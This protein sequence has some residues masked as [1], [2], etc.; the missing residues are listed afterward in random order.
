MRFL[1]ILSILIL[2]GSSFGQK[3]HISGQVQDTLNSRGVE[4]AVVMAVRVKDSVLINFVR[5]DWKGEFKLDLPRD[6]FQVFIT[7]PN[8][9]QRE[10]F[11]FGNASTKDLDFGRI[12]L[13]PKGEELKELVVFSNNQP[14][15]FKGDTLV[16]VADSFKTAANANVEDLFKKLPGFEVDNSGKI[17]VH[18]KEVNKVYVDG[19]EFFGTDPTVATK[20]LPASAIE[21]VE[22]YE[23][24]VEGDNTEETEKV[25]NLKLKE[26]AKQGYF[27][28]INGAS[29]FNNYYEGEFL[30][31]KFN[32]S[33]KISVFGLFT[34]TPRSEFNMRDRFQYG[35][36]EE[37]GLRDEDWNY[38]YEPQIGNLGEGVPQKAKTGFYY[39]DKIGKKVEIGT[40]FT[41]D[42]QQVLSRKESFTQYNLSDTTYFNSKLDSTLQMQEAYAL[43]FKLEWKID[44][45]TKLDI[46]PRVKQIQNQTFEYSVTDF[47]SEDNVNTR[48]TEIDYSENMIFQEGSLLVDLEKNFEK[49]NRKLEATY[50]IKHQSNS[51]KDYLSNKDRDMVELVDYSNLDQTKNGKSVF[52]QHFANLQFTEPI[53]KKVMLEVSYAYQVASGYNKKYTFDNDGTDYNLLNTTYTSDFDNT[54]SNQKIGGKVIFG[55]KIHQIIAG[56]YYNITDINSTDVFTDSSLHKNLGNILPYFKYRIKFSQSKQLTFKYISNVQNPSISQLQPI[57]NNRNINNIKLGNINLISEVSNQA[58]VNYFTYKATSGSHRYVGMNYTWYKN[59]LSNGLYYDNQGRVINQTINVSGGEMLT[60]YFGGQF[61]FLKQLL[62]FSPNINYIRNVNISEINF[63]ESTNENNSIYTNLVAQ[64]IT[65]SVEIFAGTEIGYNY[66]KTALSDTW[67]KYSTQTY[68]AGFEWK[69]RG[70]IEIGSEVRYIV[71]TQRANGYDLTYLLWDAS[72][73]K[74]FLPKENLIISFEAND[75]LNQN[76]SNTRSIYNNTIVDTKTNIIGRYLLLRAVYKFN[77]LKGQKNDDDLL[78]D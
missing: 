67:Q 39:T 22:V 35:L 51:S 58:S 46:V 40:N 8:F 55:H 59:P 12:I 26:D 34:N 31:N 62:K 6:T 43:N 1:I 7:H 30:V 57:P 68:K 16:M 42:N 75:I 47:Y 70:K 78:K 41:Y 19:D 63:V 28:K 53:S 13:P 60:G 37:Y 9:E 17:V 72:I 33:Q 71:N 18:G 32:G 54:T 10:F 50:Q 11:I 24:K 2:T 49:K 5:T 74:M 4:Y 3:I 73:S 77:V 56:A 14:I 66:A 52:L 61:P 48:S 64:M 20:N 25:I 29:D 76:I 27:G 23:Q 69:L 44:S 65:D 15:Y 38:V 45:L 36:T 21:N